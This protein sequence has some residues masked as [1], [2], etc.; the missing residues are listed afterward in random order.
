[1]RTSFSKLSLLALP[2]AA[3]TACQDYEPFSE[4]E[5]AN[6]KYNRHYD[7]AFKEAFGEISP[8]QNWGFDPVVVDINDYSVATR[9]SNPESNQWS[10]VYHYD[11]PGGTTV[12][13]ESWKRVPGDIT[14]YERAYVYWWFSTHPNPVSLNVDWTEFFLENVW[15]QPEHTGKNADNTNFTSQYWQA[16][17]QNN[18]HIVTLGQNSI[19]FGTGLDGVHIPGYEHI[20]DF[21][22]SGAAEE[23]VMFVYDVSTIDFAYQSSHDSKYHNNWTIQ[24]INGNYYLAFDYE[25]HKGPNNDFQDINC[26]GY[27][28][29]WI[30]KLSAGEHKVN[31][32]TRRI[33]CE[34]LG[35]TFDWD[36][37]DVVFDITPVVVTDQGNTRVFAQITL[38][39]AGGTLP[40][41]IGQVDEAH[42][43]HKLFGLNEYVP[44]NVTDG[45]KRPSVVFHIALQE[46]VNY[47]VSGG[48][49]TFDYNSIP[50]YVPSHTDNTDA[51]GTF[52]NVV[53]LE[54]ETGKAPQKFA[55]P[56]NT[57]WMNEITHIEYGHPNFW[58][59]VAGNKTESEAFSCYVENLP[60]DSKYF[61]NLYKDLGK[62]NSV[63]YYP[64]EN[65]GWSGGSMS[66]AIL[67][68]KELWDDRTSKPENS[69]FTETRSLLKSGNNYYVT[70]FE[71]QAPYIYVTSSNSDPLAVNVHHIQ[72]AVSQMEYERVWPS[73]YLVTLSADSNMGSVSGS[74]YYNQGQ[75]ATLTAT[76][77]D[78]YLFSHWSDDNTDNPRIIQVNDNISL[79]AIF[80]A[81]PAPHYDV[82][83]LPGSGYT[84]LN[85]EGNG[86]AFNVNLSGISSVEFVVVKKSSSDISASL[87]SSENAYYF[88]DQDKVVDY[89]EPVDYQNLK[90]NRKFTVTDI[91]KLKSKVNYFKPGIITGFVS[92]IW[93]KVN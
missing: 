8:T 46:G 49:Y 81:E 30:M 50:V 84:K 70:T 15:G 67:P 2:L 59:W 5:V 90:G 28:N 20:L 27:Y 33:M 68:W 51:N 11:V 79:T 6:T 71:E 40:V 89:S 39:A 85:N 23:Q 17:G 1:M 65:G 9:S 31:G 53:A 92:E 93:Y 69:Q 25:G 63:T 44:I 60:I 78:G 24:Y 29:D 22:A 72:D 47:T 73:A 87:Y 38:Q 37:N 34:D 88:G 13:Q 45:M 74:G 83:D 16:F 66:E 86:F 80:I 77:N 21:N 19:N 26:D 42:E 41:Y 54:A 7:E 36:F 10:P 32:A 4:A 12:S 61:D 18:L 52:V 14:N 62:P 58:G 91:S 3:L 82:E 64:G 43:V 55:C 48:Q 35:N 75:N 57:Y 76:P 56:V